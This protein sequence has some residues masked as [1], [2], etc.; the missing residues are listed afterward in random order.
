MT[1]TRIMAAIELLVWPAIVAAI[2]QGRA[3]PALLVAVPVGLFR[4]AVAAQA[5]FKG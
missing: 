3:W 4:M 5:L 1:S 2:V